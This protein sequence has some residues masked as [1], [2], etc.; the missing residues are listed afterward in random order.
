MPNWDDTCHDEDKNDLELIGR[1]LC[2]TQTN[3]AFEVILLDD[4]N[5][6]DVHVTGERE[7]Q[8]DGSNEILGNVFELS[9]N[10]EDFD[11]FLSPFGQRKSS[12]QKA[13]RL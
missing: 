2:P 11:H 5:D 13:V 10:K 3:I 4:D 1:K 7:S 9:S 6:E 12:T 8:N